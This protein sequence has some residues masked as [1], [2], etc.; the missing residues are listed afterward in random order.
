MANF[1][2]A[3][4][5]RRQVENELTDVGFEYVKSQLV[6][7]LDLEVVDCTHNSSFLLVRSFSCLS[8]SVNHSTTIFERAHAYANLVDG[9]R[10]VPPWLHVTLNDLYPLLF[11]NIIR[12]S[13]VLSAEGHPRQYLSRLN[14]QLRPAAQTPLSH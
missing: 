2:A 10:A 8:L 11:I 3:H 1:I 14:C 12:P 4:A 6:S 9:L 5:I 7:G 13:T